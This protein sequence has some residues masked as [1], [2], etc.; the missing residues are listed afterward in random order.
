MKERNKNK[1][2]NNKK[3]KTEGCESSF[4]FFSLFFFR[5][6]NYVYIFAWLHPVCPL[7]TYIVTG[8]LLSIYESAKMTLD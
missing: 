1:N 4:F 8:S 2:N 6:E 7:S 5:E 3:K